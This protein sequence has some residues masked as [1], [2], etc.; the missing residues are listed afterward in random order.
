LLERD[1]LIFLEKKPTEGEKAFYITEQNESLYDIAQNT[2]I[3]LESLCSYN[4]LKQNE[5]VSLGTKLY[6]KPVSGAP[7][8]FSEKNTSDAIKVYTVH[9]REGLYTIS[10]KY[11]ISVSQLK[12]WNNLPNDN[13]KVGQELIISK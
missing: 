9:A 7:E 10:K 8:N 4:N 12:E 5:T 6:L 13:L 2:G 1:Q 11:G 3:R